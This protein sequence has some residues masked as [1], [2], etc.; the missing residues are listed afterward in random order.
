MSRRDNRKSPRASNYNVSAKTLVGE[1]VEL[2]KR[3]ANEEV[4]S[5]VDYV[6][7]KHPR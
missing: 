6:R 3:Y 2:R 5:I 7:Q 4:I 1:I